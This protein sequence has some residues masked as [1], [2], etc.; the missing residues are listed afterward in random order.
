MARPPWTILTLLLFI[1]VHPVVFHL[2]PLIVIIIIITITI[3]IIPIFL[4]FLYQ[5]EEHVTYLVC[6]VELNKQQQQQNCMILVMHAL[7][8]AMMD[9]LNHDILSTSSTSMTS[10]GPIRRSYV[11]HE[12]LL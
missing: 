3:I 5:L 1:N 2:I 4:L 10:S 12:L 8:D 9:K 7:Y 6:E 11:E